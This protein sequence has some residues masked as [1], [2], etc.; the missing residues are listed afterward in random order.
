MSGH[1]D[2]L[3]LVAELLASAIRPPA[4]LPFS[5]WLPANI[6][7]I[8]GPAAGSPWSPDG[9]PYLLDIADC[10]SDDHPTNLVTI[11]K[12]QQSGASIL[13]LAW[14]LYIADREPANT[15]YA[16]PGID[17]LRDLNSA[18]LQPLVDAWQRRI[19]ET[20]IVPQ[21]SRSGS[22]STTYEKVFVR[23]GRLWLGNANAVMDLSSKT[24]KK[25]VKDELSKWQDIPGFGDPETLF[26][27]RF[28]AFRRTKDYKILEISTPEV[29]TGD[30]TG[31][32]PGHCRIDRS[33]K[34]SDQRFWNVA[35][36]ECHRLFVHDIA[37]LRIDRDHP[38]RS[39]YECLS[40]THE[41]S[42]AE[43]V[44]AVR[45]AKGEGGGWIAS[46]DG[47]DRHPGF[48]ID[49]FISLMMSYEAIAEDALRAERGSEKDRK[50]LFNLTLGL[51]FRYRGD[52]PDHK[53][54]LE[55]REEL[56]RYHVP[57]GGLI[58][59]AAADVQMRG[60]WYE[61]LAVGADRQEWTIDAGYIEGD[62]SQP[63]APVYEHLQRLTLDREF[64]DA[65]GRTRRLDALGIDSGFQSHVVYAVVRRH[66]RLHPDTGKDMVLALDGRDGWG[67]P[68][69]GTPSLVDIDL[70]GRKVRQGAKLWPVGTWPLKG[71]FY[72]DLHKE[73]VRS[74]KMSDPPGY[75]HFGMWLD[76][77]YFKQITAERLDDVV[78]RGQV[79]GRKWVKSGDN[80][81]LDARIYNRALAEYLGLSSM[82]PA[83][84][85]VLARRR[86]LPD[87]LSTVD[88]F[89]PKQS[90]APTSSDVVT[91]PVKQPAPAARDPE[92]DDYFARYARF[93]ED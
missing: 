10:L 82:T 12:S 19:R 64:P 78:V 35:C 9:A 46:V 23:G 14:C 4:P 26:F 76:E 6:V 16:A 34:R 59:T 30:E 44:A 68:A 24:A 71:A 40:C 50:D 43:R 3:R 89:T 77:A 21:T 83:D 86:G 51:P 45:N 56:T 15:L 25:G 91:V 22:G 37:R 75:C 92:P 66:Q 84:W 90:I 60:I 80:H 29:D 87:E 88:L 54:L 42:E 27:G 48:H 11:R 65:F 79:T 7:L 58:L 20:L 67:R 69:I 61:V 18:K 28:T 93:N 1:P 74:G 5:A 41:I 73:G 47:P 63:D 8:D 32:A 70:D 49:A 52:A 38:H 39:R 85:S 36:P 55:R 57:A 2:E 53:R 72:T 13:A 31:E 17:M 62:T 33:F 81:F